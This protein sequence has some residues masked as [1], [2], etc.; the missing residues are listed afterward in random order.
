MA[1]VA[2]STQCE[3]EKV[4]VAG[5]VEWDVG[6]AIAIANTVNCTSGSGGQCLQ[7][8]VDHL[9]DWQHYRYKVYDTMIPLRNILWNS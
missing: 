8:K 6:T 2:R 9:P 3:K 4:T 5:N 1:L 7:I